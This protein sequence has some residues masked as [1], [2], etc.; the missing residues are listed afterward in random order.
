MQGEIGDDEFRDYFLQF[1]EIEDSV[2]SLLPSCAPLI[3]VPSFRADQRPWLP[4]GQVLR[5]PDGG[6][7]GFGFVTFK[8]EMSVEKCLVMQHNL[9]GKTVRSVSRSSR[10]PCCAMLQSVGRSFASRS[11]HSHHICAASGSVVPCKLPP[12]PS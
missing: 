3:R 2:V 9:G 12:D 4:C 1:G 6:S 10:I 11:Q 7:R 5:K 8:D